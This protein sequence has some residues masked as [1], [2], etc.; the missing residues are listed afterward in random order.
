M[1]ATIDLT[2][3][4]GRHRMLVIAVR[5]HNHRD[6][7][8]PAHLDHGERSSGDSAPRP[9]ARQSAGR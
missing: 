3:V 6:A 8:M 1:D 2:Q 4:S 7:A 9:L 5:P